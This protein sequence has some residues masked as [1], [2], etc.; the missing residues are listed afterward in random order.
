MR[1]SLLIAVLT[2]AAAACG[3]QIPAE[4]FGIEGPIEPTEPM[5]K[6]DNAGRPGPLVATNTTA[7]QVWTAKNKWEDRD[8]PEAKK[9]GLAWGEN[10]GLNWDEK[11]A[12]WL[13]SLPIVPGTDGYPTFQLT[14]PWGKT[15]PAPVLECAESQMFL[16]ATFAAWYQLPFMLETTSREGRVYFGHFG[17]RTATGKFQNTP[18]FAQAYK[19]YSGMT[20]AELASRGWPKDTA[21][22][23]RAAAGGDDAQPAINEAHIGAYLDEVH[24][25]KRAGHFIVYLLNY[26]GSMNLADTANTYNLKPESIRAGDLLIHRWQK[27]GIGDAKMLKHVTRAENGTLQARLM[28]GSMPRRQPKIYDESSSKGYFMQEDTGG[29]GTNFDG[30]SYFKLGGGVKRWRVTKNIGGRWT[31]TWMAADE[32]SWINSTDEAA[33]TARPAQFATLLEEVS[34][35]EKKEAL[36]HQIE[37]ARAHL[38]RYPASCAARERRERAF[39]ELY[40]MA[41][42]LGTTRA[43]IDAE[44]RRL[45]DYVF[46]P[47]VYTQSK[48]CCWNSTTPQMAAIIMDYATKE[49]ATQCV[50]PT[51]FRS[52]QGGYQRWAA[53]AASI[54]Q[55]AAWKAWT[56]DE[57]CA[58]RNVAEDTVAPPTAIAWC[59]LDGGGGGSSSCSDDSF[60]PNNS[61]SAAKA[62][63][64]GQQLQAKI[65]PNNE[66]YFKIT[67]AAGRGIDARITFQHAAGD[68]DL[69]LLGPTGQRVAI[70]EG[71][72]DSERV[73]ATGLAAGD[74]TLRVYGYAGAGGAYTLSVTVQ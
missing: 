71:T 16:R 49:Q 61:R 14:T 65:C 51:V 59:S 6:E 54:G 26:L 7:T 34:P 22:R 32:A 10:S 15:M 23:A 72:T 17:I 3:G 37:D 48:T 35:E 44:Y 36:L 69:E 30:D 28:S 13:E 45:E 27:S 38:L 73:A 20:A 64:S 55:A 4:D 50:A 1:R 12:A 31:N 46:A 19:D 68:L 47:L 41:G 42:E 21:L 74:Y 57:T 53:H 67:V 8:T 52:E 33:I 5:G 2:T 39:T 24:L 58:Q 18:N 62:V 43:R 9:A 56:E 63:T 29:P 66:D 11:F 60:E 40:A 70:S 25:N